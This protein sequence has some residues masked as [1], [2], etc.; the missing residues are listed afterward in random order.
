VLLSS[1]DCKLTGTS[2]QNKVVFPKPASFSEAETQPSLL[3][4]KKFSE[5]M[6]ASGRDELRVGVS[7]EPGLLL[8]GLFLAAGPPRTP[9]LPIS[10]FL[11]R[12]KIETT[13]SRGVNQRASYSSNWKAVRET[14]SDHARQK[15]HQ[16]SNVY[17]SSVLAERVGVRSL[18]NHNFLRP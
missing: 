4:L 1:V 2:R 18:Q 10:T 13:T 12:K 6:A 8:P 5:P 7:P 14:W 3:A 11:Q 15:F 17:H 16:G 9:S